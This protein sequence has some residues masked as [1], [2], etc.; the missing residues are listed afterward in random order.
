MYICKKGNTYEYLNKIHRGRK[1]L[2]MLANACK[3]LANACKM[4]ANAC[5]MLAN[6]C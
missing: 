6:A 2:Q 3:M 4:L 1:C 5:K